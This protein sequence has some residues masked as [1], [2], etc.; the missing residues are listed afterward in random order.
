[1]EAGLHLPQIDLTGEGLTASRLFG[2]VGAARTNGFVALSANDHFLFAT[3]WLDGL[4]LLSAVVEGSGELTLATTIALAPLRGPVPLA[5]ALTTLQVLSNGR[6]EAG[7]GPGSSRRDYDALGVSFDERWPR[8]DESVVLLRSLLRG[9]VPDAEPALF[10]VP[11]SPLRPVVPVPLW[12]GSWGSGSGLRRV[13]RLADGWLASAYNTSPAGFGAAWS[14]LR[15]TLTRTG[16]RDA[17]TFGNALVTMWTWVTED[18]E[19]E[20]RVLHDVLSPLL[21]RD[22][23]DLAAQLCV[24]PANRCRELVEQY[25]AAGCRRIH[26]WPVGDESR[27]V[28]L[29]A[30]RVLS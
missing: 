1:M 6:V 13:A 14:D 4:S 25:A 30:S 29:L 18:A 22:P 28:E 27:Q 17:D 19:Q 8:F 2:S 12:I 16:H 10:A 9:H 15:Q 7:V 5:K 26:F 24:G 20:R 3:P 23:E 11:D 21:R